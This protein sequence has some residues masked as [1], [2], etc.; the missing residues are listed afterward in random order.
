[1]YVDVI[2]VYQGICPRRGMVSTNSGQREIS[3]IKYDVTIQK[4]VVVI[5]SAVRI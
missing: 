1:M 2:L 3:A 4:A 5:D